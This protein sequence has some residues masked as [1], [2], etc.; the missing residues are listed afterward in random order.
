L[1]RRAQVIPAFVAF[2]DESGRAV[3]IKPTLGTAPATIVH[4]VRDESTID[5]L[6]VTADG[7]AV[8]VGER[9]ACAALVRRIDVSNGATVTFLEGESTPKLSPDGRWLATIVHEE[10]AGSCQARVR[11]RDLVAATSYEIDGTADRAPNSFAWSPDSTRLAYVT[12]DE[13]CVL[14]AD[15]VAARVTTRFGSDAYITYPQRSGPYRVEPSVSWSALGSLTANGTCACEPHVASLSAS[16][17]ESN[18]PSL[19]AYPP[20]TDADIL[21]WERGE[22]ELVLGEMEHGAAPVYRR[23]GRGPLI[24]LG[25]RSNGFVAW[26]SARGWEGP[27][28]SKGAEGTTDDDPRQC[29]G[30]L[31]H[32]RVRHRCHDPNTLR[33][34]HRRIRPR[35]NTQ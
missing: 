8:L 29:A 5:G 18:N 16:V 20:E 9:S 27:L 1:A 10:R 2:V 4:R 24:P 21:Q 17:D 26:P 7:T 25:I 23:H 32:R 3:G 19:R 13:R 14:F 35:P 11:V 33:E 30:L 22:N 28:P 15:T 6:T 12:C 31:G 34:Q